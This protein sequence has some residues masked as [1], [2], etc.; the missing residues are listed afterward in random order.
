[1]RLGWDEVKQRAKGAH[2]TTAANILKMIGPLFLD[3]LKAELAAIVAR[4]RIVAGC[5]V[6]AHGRDLGVRLPE[7]G[8]KIQNQN[9]YNRIINI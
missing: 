4:R 7:D 6:G 9:I 3:D 1:M 8:L 5:R 2:D